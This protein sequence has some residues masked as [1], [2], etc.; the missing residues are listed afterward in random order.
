MSILCF[1]SLQMAIRHLHLHQSQ[2][3]L[4]G[5]R[6]VHQTLRVLQVILHQLVHFPVHASYRLFL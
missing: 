1:P 5:A 6:Q 3:C 4:S 2:P